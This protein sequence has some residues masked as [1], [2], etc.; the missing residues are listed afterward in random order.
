MKSLRVSAVALSLTVASL[1]TVVVAAQPSS[2]AGVPATISRSVTIT[3]DSISV[4][5]PAAGPR[6]I[7]LKGATYTWRESMD[8]VVQD[9]A[10]TLVLAAGDYDWQC[11][12]TGPTL[13]QFL[14][15]SYCRLENV[16]TGGVAYLPYSGFDEFALGEGTHTWTN[17]LTPNS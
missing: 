17:T 8:T 11:A 5:L 12:L 2:A 14:Y 16:S 6:R 7:T 15:Y 13:D 10:R 9:P 3:G 1:A 4:K